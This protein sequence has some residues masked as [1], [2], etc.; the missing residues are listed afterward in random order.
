LLCSPES[1]AEPSGILGTLLGIHSTFD[2]SMIL[3]ENIVQ[4]LHRPVSTAIA[5][6]LFLLTVGMAER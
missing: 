4:V 2:G 5:Q 1:F 6:R 3:F